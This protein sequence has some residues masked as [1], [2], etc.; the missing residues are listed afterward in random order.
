MTFIYWFLK[1]GWLLLLIFIG[2]IYLSGMG[3]WSVVICVF[4]FLL[5]NRFINIQMDHYIKQSFL[6]IFPVLAELK[7]G[8][9]IQVKLKNGDKLTNRVF[10][11]ASTTEILSGPEQLPTEG[12]LVE[13]EKTRW[14]KLKK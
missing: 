1:I 12:I 2:N 5:G 4:V 9:S 3:L 8:Q 14:I 11:I 6:K 13:T 7:G 10:I